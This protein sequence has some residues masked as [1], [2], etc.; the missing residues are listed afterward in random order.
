MEGGQG[1]EGGGRYRELT[2]CNINPYVAAV[3]IA[4]KRCPLYLELKVSIRISLRKAVNFYFFI[5]YFPRKLA[6]W[7]FKYMDAAKEKPCI[8][9][10]SR[11][12]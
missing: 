2:R 5:T 11:K 8:A 6:K 1:G 9:K 3:I 12:R 7:N 10:G 4:A